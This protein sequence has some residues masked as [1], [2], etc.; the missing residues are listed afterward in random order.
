MKVNNRVKKTL[1]YIFILYDQLSCDQN[2]PVYFFVLIPIVELHEL[3]AHSFHHK[4]GNGESVILLWI[5]R[6]TSLLWNFFAYLLFGSINDLI[7]KNIMLELLSFEFYSKRIYLFPIFS[8]FIPLV[9]FQDVI[10]LCWLSH[11]PIFKFYLN[12]DML[13]IIYERV[14]FLVREYFCPLWITR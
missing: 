4:E 14:A 8:G 9:N 1:C 10:C 12:C 13:V 6:R 7:I 5:Y 3:L 11:I 2:S